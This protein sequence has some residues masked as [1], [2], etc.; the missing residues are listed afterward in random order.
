MTEIK[1][2]KKILQAI[3]GFVRPPKNK[4]IEK[5]INFKNGIRTKYINKSL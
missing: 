2:G 5:P 4:Q 3:K 1:R